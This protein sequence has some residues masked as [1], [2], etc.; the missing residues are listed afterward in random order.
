VTDEPS[1]KYTLT[2]AQR[3]FVISLKNKLNAYDDNVSCPY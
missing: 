1:G 3:N 2:S